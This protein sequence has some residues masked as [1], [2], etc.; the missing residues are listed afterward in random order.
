MTD[1]NLTVQMK[2]SIKA[3]IMAIE[4][5]FNLIDEKII[6]MKKELKEIVEALE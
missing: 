6:F 2:V 4:R 1:S 3:D 5:L